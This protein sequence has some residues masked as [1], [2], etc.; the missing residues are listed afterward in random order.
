MYNRLR[1][2]QSGSSVVGVR[3]PVHAGRLLRGVAIGFVVRKDILLGSVDGCDIVPDWE[4]TRSA[5]QDLGLSWLS[6]ELRLNSGLSGLCD[7]S[8]VSVARASVAS[9]GISHEG[10]PVW[11]SLLRGCR[12]LHA[13]F[14]AS[15]RARNAAKTVA[16]GRND[17]GEMCLGG[18]VSS[19]LV[20]QVL[21][22]SI[23]GTVRA[24]ARIVLQPEAIG[25]GVAFLEAV[26]T[27]VSTCLATLMIQMAL[28]TAVEASH[29]SLILATHVVAVSTKSAVGALNGTLHKADGSGVHR[30]A[31]W[32]DR[33]DGEG[34]RL[35][36]TGLGLG[37]CEDRGLIECSCLRRRCGVW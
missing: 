32:A 9:G 29:L 18:K 19:L 27:L 31:V 4:G 30:R 34:A 1:C 5:L 16:G 15:I 21:S 33:V 2:R 24:L 12:G 11:C 20:T 35:H 23:I 6:L 28:D 14:G 3:R 22:V 8:S 7:R 17:A 25:L 37:Q 36:G 10:A 13:E 26:A